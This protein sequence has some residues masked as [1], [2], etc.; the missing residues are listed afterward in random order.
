MTEKHPAD[1]AAEHVESAPPI[2]M[3]F[4]GSNPRE[5][6]SSVIVSAVSTDRRLEENMPES[7][8]TS[9]FKFWRCKSPPISGASKSPFCFWIACYI[10][11]GAARSD[12]FITEIPAARSSPSLCIAASKTLSDGLLPVYDTSRTWIL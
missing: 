9:E 6:A 5:T 10:D 12:A 3:T 11:D 8:M 7:M 1:D 2:N 4:F